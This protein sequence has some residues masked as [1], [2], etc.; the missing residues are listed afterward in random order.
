M[1]NLFMSRRK[2]RTL[3]EQKYT[4]A[5]MN[6]LVVIVFT[7]VNMALLGLQTGFYFPFSIFLP[8]F[9]M[10]MGMFLCGYYPPEAYEGLEDMVFSDQSVFVTYLIVAIV[11]AL[12]ALI[13]FF[14]SGKNRV[15]GLTSA[16]VFIGLDTGA[17]LLFEGISLYSILDH[18]FHAWIICEL[19]MG[20]KAG[21][22]LKALNTKKRFGIFGRK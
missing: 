14:L 9:L 17:I 5:R 12:C 7:F 11:I 13:I 19:V 21:N 16:L 18:F 15:S 22:E 4:R 6:L 1:A 8:Y 2:Q 20:I 10:D 3:L